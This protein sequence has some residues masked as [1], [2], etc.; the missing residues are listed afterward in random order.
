[1][2]DVVAMAQMEQHLSTIPPRTW[3]QLISSQSVIQKQ[4]LYLTLRG[5]GKEV[6]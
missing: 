5:K 3:L 1:L 4:S 2:V 6:G